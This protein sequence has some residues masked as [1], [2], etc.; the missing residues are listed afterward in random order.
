MSP[1]AID[2]P[3]VPRHHSFTSIFLWLFLLDGIVGLVL[4]AGSLSGGALYE[5]ERFENVLVPF[6][7]AL[8]MGAVVQVVIAYTGRQRWSARLVGLY[9]VG[10]QAMGLGIFMVSSLILLATRGPQAPL[11][12]ES[13]LPGTAVGALNL[14][15]GGL[16][17][18]LWIWAARDLSSGHYLD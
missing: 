11:P 10:Y 17:V 2:G 16:Q 9:V 1:E 3:A 7:L 8:L 13:L 18:L 6:S 12:E 15:I 5:T 4:G 14:A